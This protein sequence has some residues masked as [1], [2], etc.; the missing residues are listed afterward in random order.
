[1]V[2][3]RIRIETEAKKP[4]SIYRRLYGVTPLDNSEQR[5][6][7]WHKAWMRY[8]KKDIMV[9]LINGEWISH[10]EVKA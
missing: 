4:K 6:D 10:G 7:R 3:H 8:N 9:Y 2:L 5:K 1:M